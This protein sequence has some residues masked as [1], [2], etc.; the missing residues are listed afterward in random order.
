MKT[1]KSSHNKTIIQY[2]HARLLMKKLVYLKLHG[3]L[4]DYIVKKMSIGLRFV[5]YYIYYNNLQKGIGKSEFQNKIKINEK[6]YNS[7]FN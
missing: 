2:N 1:T 4:I 3:F 6:K 7:T 5:K